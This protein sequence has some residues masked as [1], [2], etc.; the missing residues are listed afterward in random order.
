MLFCIDHDNNIYIENGSRKCLSRKGRD[1]L[2]SEEEDFLFWEHIDTN[3][4]ELVEKKTML[5]GKRSI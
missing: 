3:D 4:G 2:K 1:G 5:K